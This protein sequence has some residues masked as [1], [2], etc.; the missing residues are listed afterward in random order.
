M[1]NISRQ[2]CQRSTIH[3]QKMPALLLSC[4]IIVVERNLFYFCSILVITA[5]FS[6]GC[7]PF[8]QRHSLLIFL[9]HQEKEKGQTMKAK[10]REKRKKSHSLASP[11]SFS[12]LWPLCYIH[13]ISCASDLEEVVFI[14]YLMFDSRIV[15][16]L[17]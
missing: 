12:F 14:L 17:L 16:G 6:R 2:S 1:N 5:F 3:Q 9:P 4:I 8:S 11:Y 7:P 15:H 10:K 13:S